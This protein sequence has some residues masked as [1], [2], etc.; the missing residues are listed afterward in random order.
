MA[1]R[2]GLLL[3]MLPAH[4]KQ[5]VIELIQTTV[6][7]NGGVANAQVIRHIR[8]RLR[9]QWAIDATEDDVNMAVTNLGLSSPPPPPQITPA[10][11]DAESQTAL[12]F[13]LLHGYLGENGDNRAPPH[14][15]IQICH[16]LQAVLSMQHNRALA[17]R[18]HAEARANA[19]GGTPGTPETLAA[20]RAQSSF[21]M[22]YNV[23][24]GS[25][26]PSAY[27]TLPPIGAG[28][29]A[30]LLKALDKVGVY[31]RV[32]PFPDMVTSQCSRRSGCRIFTDAGQPVPAANGSGL[33]D[34]LMP[35]NMN[36]QGPY[37][38]SGRYYAEVQ[39]L[40]KAIYG[41]VKLAHVVIA[42]GQSLVWTDERVAIKCISKAVVRRMKESG[43]TMNENPLKEVRCL[44]YIT[45]RMSGALEGPEV[46]R[47]DPRFVLPM[48]DCLEDN[49]N[50][51]L[52]MPCLEQEMFTV[53]ESKAGP[54]S[55]LEAR[56]YLSQII[57]GLE[58][59]HSLGLAHHDMSLEN[60]MTNRDGA[61][62]IIDWGMVVKVPLTDQGVPVKIASNKE[63]P[64][65]CGKL[66]YLA[67]E[68]LGA[69]EASPAFDP[70]K[71]DIWSI[72]V[73]LFVLLTG[74]PPWDVR[75]GPTP[76]DKRFQH[77]IQ[78]HLSALLAAWRIELSPGAVELL[79]ALLRGDPQ[80]RPTIPQIRTFP[81]FIS[82]PS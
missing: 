69:S 59:A 44:S 80:Q 53:V 16:G 21:E 71:L 62:V 77:V 3:D 4:I 54:F 11:Q 8:D 39:V 68:L 19:Q 1:G 36:G 74:V 38:G 2:G 81:W 63:W 32:D 48:V 47:G 24:V 56:N 20:A 15:D 5:A 13:S 31:A 42:N 6:R 40:K 9:Q 79:Q 52:V 66:L 65:K 25:A 43:N 14:L 7:E 34:V 58:V 46:I 35:T 57:D 49:E 28:G 27:E 18:A 60:L 37:S 82:P 12:L 45:R 33:F 30:A 23:I 10:P 75:T 26:Q 61:A 51:Y 41:C 17:R 78:G 76:R 50:I 64:C 22:V 73:M 55:E 72:G 70:F 67:P 29:R